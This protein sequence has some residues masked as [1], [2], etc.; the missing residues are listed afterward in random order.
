MFLARRKINEESPGDSVNDYV[1]RL[2]NHFIW[3]LV[4][5]LT[6]G[7]M[8]PIVL[9]FAAVYELSGKLPR[10]IDA[11]LEP[12]DI[13]LLFAALLCGHLAEI[14]EKR[15]HTRAAGA[16]LL[17]ILGTTIGVSVQASEVVHPA[18]NDLAN[19]WP[20]A[21]VYALMVVVLI[22]STIAL[23]KNK[24]ESAAERE[25]TLERESTP[26]QES[27]SERPKSVGS[28]QRGPPSEPAWWRTP[29]WWSRRRRA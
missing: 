13:Y 21:I 26:E 1:T 23:R 16:F 20:L 7:I 11:L 25:P 18:L 28:A 29:G 22:M 4:F 10:S 15:R 6:L 27:G 17:I 9:A 3:F 5:E 8:A 2:L 12:R 14:A 24:E 19:T